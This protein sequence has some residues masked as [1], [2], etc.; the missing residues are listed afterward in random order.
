[1]QNN[2]IFIQ[3]AAYRDPELV[4]TIENCLNEAKYPD[5]LVFCIG[6]QFNNE[7]PF[8]KDLDKYRDD[9]RFKIIDVPYNEAKGVCWMRSQIQKYWDGEEYTLQLDSH[10][11]FIPNWDVELKDTLN[12]LRVKGTQKPIISSYAPAYFPK[13]DPE[14]RQYQIWGLT[15]D[16]FLPEGPPFL[17][18][19]VLSEVPLDEPIPGRFLSGHFIFTLG[20][21]C[22]EVQYD[23]SFYFHGEE[24]SLAVRA[25][26]H[27]YDIFIPNKVFIWHEY[28]RSDKSK[29]WGDHTNYGDL[30]K[31]SYA[32]FRSLFGVGGECSPCAK[33]AMANYWFGDKRTLAQYE[34]YSGIKFSTKQLHKKTIQR[35]HPP[36][37]FDTNEF[38]ANLASPI[39]YYINVYKGSL[40]ESDYDMLVVAF[41]DE[42]GNDLFRKDADEFEIQNLIN[43]DPNDQFIHILREYEDTRQPYKS[44]VWPHSKSKGWCERIEQL[45]PYA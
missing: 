38:E 21:F 1:M 3:I 8:T 39:K 15:V 27:G 28:T 31:T 24:S 29:H 30:D 33:N 44:L 6:H 18:P 2:K 43:Q 4:P 40:T 11:R 7:D 9:P 37:S 35:Q 26:T 5:K 14:G 34:L 10:H 12:Y 17:T 20:Q 32:R 23:P 22:T 19:D 16:R 42:E 41:L 36:I 13:S 45:I 25:Y